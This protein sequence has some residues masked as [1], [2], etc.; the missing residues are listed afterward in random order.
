MLANTADIVVDDSNAAQKIAAEVLNNNFTTCID[1]EFSELEDSWATYS[2]LTAAECC[3]RLRPVT[4][5]N[6]WAFVQ[7]TRD[8]IRVDEYPAA[9]H[10]NVIYRNDRMEQYNTRKKWTDD[11]S[12]MAKKLT[13]KS[14][15]VDGLESKYL[16]LSDVTTPKDQG[17]PQLCCE[18]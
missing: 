15:Q 10:L 13:T 17:S 8:I 6:I 7:W 4:K 18:G 5:D 12:S 1:I 2:S 9:V 14:Y 16:Q 11:T 3:I